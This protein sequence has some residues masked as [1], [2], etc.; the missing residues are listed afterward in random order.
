[1]SIYQINPFFN[2]AF[3]TYFFDR[4]PLKNLILKVLNKIIRTSLKLRRDLAG[5]QLLVN[6]RIVEYPQILRWIKPEGK[7]LDIGCVTSRMPMQ[8]AS[9]GY[10]VHGL[11]YRKYPF[12]HP[13]L[14][15]IQSDFFKWE[16]ENRYDVILLV[17]AVEHF[18]LGD[19][20]DMVVENAD[21]I[22]AERIAGWLAPEGQFIVTVPFGKSAVTKKQRVYDLD[23]L[24]R[25]FGDFEWVDQKFYGRI[26]GSWMPRDPADLTEMDSASLPS[27]AVALLNLKNK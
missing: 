15:S 9:L 21:R 13:N 11:D 17:S 2:D 14:R 5:G 22:A 27:D 26:D 25:V 16:P 12:E 20:G 18:G 7:V 8:L 1:M 19:Y 4:G 6:E 23:A 24:K 10:T 3:E